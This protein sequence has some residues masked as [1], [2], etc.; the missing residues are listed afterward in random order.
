M[1]FNN[2]AFMYLKPWTGVR[3]HLPQPKPYSGWPI[4]GIGGGLLIAGRWGLEKLMSAIGLTHRNGFPGRDRRRGALW[5]DRLQSVT[6]R[7]RCWW[8]KKILLH[9]RSEPQRIRSEVGRPASARSASAE[10][11]PASPPGHAGRHEQIV[12]TTPAG[13]ASETR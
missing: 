2:Y 4:A 11:R 9:F 6:G 13:S 7:T 5:P 8:T 1:F 3:M 12:G 10:A